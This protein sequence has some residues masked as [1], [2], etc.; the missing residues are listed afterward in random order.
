MS[1]CMATQGMP[2]LATQGF[3]FLNTHKRLIPSCM[4][5]LAWPL[6]VL[7]LL[8]RDSWNALPVQTCILSETEWRIIVCH[9]GE[10]PGPTV[11]TVP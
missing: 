8:D 6:D 9:T 1:A 7:V 10:Q 11:V 5:C 2:G 3:S 4:K